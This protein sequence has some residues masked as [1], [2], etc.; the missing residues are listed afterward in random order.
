MEQ[1]PQ[2]E[3]THENEEVAIVEEAGEQDLSED[4]RLEFDADEEEPEK[5]EPETRT[6]EEEVEQPA[7]IVENETAA[8]AAP[9]NVQSLSILTND[10]DDDDS[11]EAAEDPNVTRDIMNTTVDKSTHVLPCTSFYKPKEAEE[12]VALPVAAPQESGVEATSEAAKKP[13]GGARIVRPTQKLNVVETVLVRK[14]KEEEVVVKK[15]VEVFNREAGPRIVK[16]MESSVSGAPVESAAPAKKLSKAAGGSKSSSRMPDF[17]ALHEKEFSKMESVAEHVQR[18][19]ATFLAKQKSMANVQTALSAIVPA[20]EVAAPAAVVLAQK[21]KTPM[22]S[23]FASRIK[24]HFASTSNITS[25]A[26]KTALNTDATKTP[27]AKQSSTPKLAKSIANTASNI[28]STIRSNIP[29]FMQVSS[30]VNTIF[31]L[32]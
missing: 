21:T 9:Q 15:V 19:Q 30:R 2:V 22:S 18:K 32:F 28:M 7:E 17:K 5:C 25:S 8:V 29:K 1:E 26:T 12:G 14:N 31:S 4:I 10:E 11:K 6:E 27:L 3:A 13:T 23:R 20:D 16:P 24:S